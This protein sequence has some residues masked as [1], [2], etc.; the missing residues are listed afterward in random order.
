MQSIMEGKA[1]YAKELAD[2]YA[3]QQAEAA[4]EARAKAAAIV[5]SAAARQCLAVIGLIVTI[6]VA[7]GSIIN[8]MIVNYLI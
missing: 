4:A 8:H 2:R 5:N 3:K 6:T 7:A 1:A